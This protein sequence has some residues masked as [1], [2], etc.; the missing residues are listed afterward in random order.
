M[1]IVFFLFHQSEIF[2]TFVLWYLKSKMI[3]SDVW[4]FEWINNIGENLKKTGI[5]NCQCLWYLS[6][7]VIY[8]FYELLCLTKMYHT[9]FW[10][11][12]LIHIHAY[13]KSLVHIH[14][15][16]QRKWRWFLWKYY[17]IK[18][19]NGNLRIIEAFFFF[20]SLDSERTLRLSFPLLSTVNI[21][22]LEGT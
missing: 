16:F 10:E 19:W 1:C 22:L 21:L 14:F 4:Y 5:Y 9:P 8:W 11:R 6:A 2:N 20:I 12:E 17:E 18:D 3:I 15:Y 7:A 13:E